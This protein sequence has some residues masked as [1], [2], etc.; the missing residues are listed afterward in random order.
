MPTQWHVA[1]GHVNSRLRRREPHTIIHRLGRSVSRMNGRRCGDD[2]GEQM[3]DRGSLL[4]GTRALL[5]CLSDWKREVSV[6]ACD[7]SQG[8]VPILR[9]SI[10]RRQLDCLEVAI[11]L[12]ESQRGYA[13][14]PLLRSLLPGFVAIHVE[15][16]PCTA[17]SSRSNQPSHAFLRCSRM[18]RFRRKSNRTNHGFVGASTK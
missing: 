13:A 4:A 5:S 6:L 10:L 1:W 16:H 11:D 9:R 12:V 8:F 2:R 3:S 7:G 15:S 17:R 14:V 18:M